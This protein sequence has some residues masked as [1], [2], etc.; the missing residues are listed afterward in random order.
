M[1]EFITL[2]GGASAAWPL[3]GRA[4]QPEGIRRIAL[5]PL[6]TGSDLEAQA[7]V[8]ALRQSLEQLGWIDGQNIRIDIRWESGETGRM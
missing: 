6:G 5:F 8:R 2:L 7:Y 1:R 3:N 4:Q